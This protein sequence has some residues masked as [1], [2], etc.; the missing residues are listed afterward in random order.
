MINNILYKRVS[1]QFLKAQPFSRSMLGLQNYNCLNNH[2]DSNYGM[3]ETYL[4]ARTYVAAAKNTGK[5][6]T[7][8]GGA[9][10]DEKAQKKLNAGAKAALKMFASFGDASAGLPS[11]TPEETEELSELAK[12]YNATTTKRSNA[13]MEDLQ[14]KIDLLHEALD[15]L[16]LEEQEFA[17]TPDTSPVPLHRPMIVDNPPV[18]DYDAKKLRDN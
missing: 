4:H 2:S 6:K 9:K 15:A 10:I 14:L 12:Q 16:P 1:K 8:D 7:G 13:E 11:L 17:R 3:Y 18:K 5:K